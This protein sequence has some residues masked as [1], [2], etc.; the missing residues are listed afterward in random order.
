MNAR[1]ESMSAANAFVPRQ[2]VNAQD[3][4]FGNT[5]DALL[6]CVSTR[7]QPNDWMT[8]GAM[9]IDR[10]KRLPAYPF[11][12]WNKAAQHLATR[13]FSGPSDRSPMRQLGQRFVDQ[14]QS[15][16][17]GKALFTALQLFSAERIVER[18]TRSFRTANSYTETQVIR[19]GAHMA[20]LSFNLV[21]TDGH[22]TWGVL[23]QGLA[24]AG[25]A[26]VRVSLVD[27]QGL[28]ARYRVQWGR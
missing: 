3:V 11:A 16:L 27:Q 28:G 23:E 19:D 12:T 10:K 18:M 13:C 5:V 2:T 8:L 1:P 9:G 20:T 22:F 17:V 7:M 24:L 15:T 14:Y 4:V 21:E 26:F 6:A 25:V